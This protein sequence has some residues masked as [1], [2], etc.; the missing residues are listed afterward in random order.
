MMCLTKLVKLHHVCCSL[1]SWTQLPSLGEA[2]LGMEVSNY[3]EGIYSIPTH[4][5]HL[6]LSIYKVVLL[7]MLSTR[8]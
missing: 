5:P 8:F 7:I 1:M 6:F 4:L 3:Y 2:T